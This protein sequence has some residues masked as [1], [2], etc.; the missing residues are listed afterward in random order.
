M[1][2][3]RSF[4]LLAFK[5]SV[6]SSATESATRG[7]ESMGAVVLIV[8]DSMSERDSIKRLESPVMSSK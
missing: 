5:S 6:V 7:A 4:G 3:D 8:G 1:D 2:C